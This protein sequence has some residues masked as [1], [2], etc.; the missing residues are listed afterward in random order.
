MT[1]KSTIFYG[2]SSGEHFS[3]S[4]IE[5]FADRSGWRGIL[6]LKSSHFLLNDY[7]FY[8]DDLDVFHADVTK[9]YQDLN[10]SARLQMRYESNLIEMSVTNRGHVVSSGHFET[11][12]NSLDFEFTLDQTYLP[13]FL[14]SISAILRE[15]NAAEQDA[16]ANP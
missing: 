6:N 13:D 4:S 5:R 9:I 8:F 16:A 14:K 15:I 7:Q 1:S 11:L 10:G 2:D 3:L 12:S